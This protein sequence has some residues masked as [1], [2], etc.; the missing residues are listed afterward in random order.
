MNITEF[1]RWSSAPLYPSN[2]MNV[3]K[4][5]LRMR[6]PKNAYT[7]R[8]SIQDANE[9]QKNKTY[10][11]MSAFK[12]TNPIH[13][14]GRLY[15]EDPQAEWRVKNHVESSKTRPASMCRGANCI[16]DIIRLHSKNMAENTMELNLRRLNLSTGR[17]SYAPQRLR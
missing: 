6:D 10:T 15:G 9:H 2:N 5:Q 12:G 7:T 11:I 16:P 4:K 13:T 14:L 3:E 8:Q 1:E 17:Y